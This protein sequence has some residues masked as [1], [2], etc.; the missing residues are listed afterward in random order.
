MRTLTI[1]SA[2]FLFL[3]SHLSG[4]DLAGFDDSYFWPLKLEK[5]F[6]SGFGDSRPGRF[7]MGVDLRTGGKPG[8]KVY[9]AEDGYV[10]RIKTSYR[11][12]GK[13]LYLMG[14]SGRLYIYG[15]LQK[16]NWDIGTFL[17]KRQIESKRY[18]QDIYPEKDLLPVKKGQHIAR[19]GQ[20]GAGAPHLHFEIRD[21]LGRPVNP[22]FFNDIKIADTTPP[23]FQAVWLTYSDSGSIFENGRREK[24][25]I[26]TF[27]STNGNYNIE[28][29]PTVTGQFVIKVAVE[30][31]LAPGSFGLGPSSIS[32]YIDDSLYHKVD[33]DRIDYAENIYSLLD[34]DFDPAKKEHKRI[35]NLFIRTGNWFSNYDSEVSGNSSFEGLSNGRHEAKII[36]VDHFG[37]SS[38]LM[39]SFNYLV[40]YKV[41][42]SF[43]R[44]RYSDS[45]IVLQLAPPELRADFDSLIVLTADD[46]GLHRQVSIAVE[47]QPNSVILKGDFTRGTSYQ[48]IFANG[49]QTYPPYLLAIKNIPPDGRVIIDSIIAEIIEGGVLLTARAIENDINWLMA[50]IQTDN[51]IYRLPYSKT[52]P[53]RFSLFFKPESNFDRI[54]KIIIHGPVGY[55]PDSLTLEIYRIE[56]GVE[57]LTPFNSVSSLLLEPGDLFDDAL[58]HLKDTIMEAPSTGYFVS[59]P[60]ILNPFTEAFADW[61]D[62]QTYLPDNVDPA[63][64]GLYVFDEDDGWL[65]AG[66]EYDSSDGKLHSPLGGGGIIAVIADTT[67]PAISN[68]NI[69]KGGRIKSSRPLIRF[70]LEDELSGIENDLNFD[71]TIDKK[72]IVPEY[73]PEQKL[74]SGKPHWSLSGGKHI[75]R[76]VVHD[77]CGNKTSFTRRFM[78]GAKIGP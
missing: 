17:Q 26:P 31:F 20:T 3:S 7:H 53:N 24:K 58:L 38:Q 40:Q 66:G 67:A 45:L 64:T 77:H 1:I 51:G 8:A 70:T 60:Y 68:L 33:Y 9:A 73:D 76:I 48:L 36:A 11:G 2:I 23:D 15:H 61:G 56:A 47:I 62:W 4:A 5:R 39:F 59:G 29:M 55:R 69:R 12:Y 71:V 32:L 6:S 44:A 19:T 37:N 63:K 34:R 22:L 16:Y 74:F 52:G 54:D 42:A 25:L 75:L 27:D 28:N 50:T 14:A 65:W 35:F 30:D 49:N 18:Y 21:S 41:L 13:G 57:T 46:N 10:W 43:N 78:V 72:W